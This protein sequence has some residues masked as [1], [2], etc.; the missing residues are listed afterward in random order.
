MKNIH[1]YEVKKYTMD[2]EK[3]EF[4][5]EIELDRKRKKVVFSEVFAYFFENEIPYSVIL[6]LEKW[7]IDRFCEDNWEVLAKRKNSSWP[8][9]Y[10]NIGE[11]EEIINEKELNYFVLYASYGMNGWILAKEVTIIDIKE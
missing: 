10:N 6:D 4:V 1:D 11:L 3:K 7:D 8:T 9:S 2:F 5:F